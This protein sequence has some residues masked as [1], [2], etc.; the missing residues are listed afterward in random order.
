MR[1]QFP[2]GNKQLNC[3][4]L[5]QTRPK[6]KVDPSA[7]N[8]RFLTFI[9]RRPFHSPSANQQNFFKRRRHPSGTRLTVQVSRDFPPKSPTQG[10]TRGRNHLIIAALPVEWINSFRNVQ[11]KNFLQIQFVVRIKHLDAPYGPRLIFFYNPPS[12]DFFFL[13]KWKKKHTQ[14]F[15]VE[16]GEAEKGCPRPQ[17]GFI[18]MGPGVT[19]FFLLFICRLWTTF[20]SIFLT[21]HIPHASRD[22]FGTFFRQFFKHFFRRKRCSVA[23]FAKFK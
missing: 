10:G 12:C 18:T 16:R 19:S 5:A 13:I 6:F 2:D 9:K 1:H 8:Q 23:R 21:F 4:Q 11:L 17:K 22:F 3:G 14:F 20:S 15:S 7:E